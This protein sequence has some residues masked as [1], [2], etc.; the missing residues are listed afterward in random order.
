M[1]A[2]YR[3]VSGPGSILGG[4]LSLTGVGALVV[5][6]EQPGDANWLAA[7]PVTNRVT[8]GRGVQV[9]TF[10]PIGDQTLG[11]GPV[12]LVARASSGLPVTFSV[13]S[14][15]AAVDNDRLAFSAEGVVTVR[16]INPGSSLWLSASADQTIAVRKQTRLAVTVAGNLG[17]SVAVAPV[18]DQYLATDTVTLTATP[19]SGFAFSAWS[20]DLT[21][22]AN[23]ASLSM[24]ANRS[25]VA[26]FKDITPPSIIWEL[27]VAGTS[28]IELFRLLGK[29]NDNSTV[30]TVL[31][32]RDGGLGQPL[33]LGAD[34]SFKLENLV[35]ASGTNRFALVARDAAGNE[36]RLEREVVWMPQRI[37]R[38]AAADSSQEGQ[39]LVF[40]LELTSPGDVAGLTFELRYDP[41]F[42]AD[43]QIEWS[44]AVGQSVNN[45]NA[46]T[47]GKVAATFS[48]AGSALPG[49]IQR[50]A[51]VSFRGR[52]V[53]AAKTVDLE[54]RW[55]SASSSTGALLANGNA[56]VTGSGR[57]VPRRIQGD[58]N[59]N[60][61]I[62]IGDA[63]LISR[64]QVELEEVRPWDV[65]LNDL[66]GSGLIDN[67]DVV[68]ALR[69]VVGLDPQPT[70]GSEA[71]RLANALGLAKAQVNTNDAIILEA[72][73][74]PVATVGQPYRIAIRLNRVRG[75]LSGLRFTLNYPNGL[76]LTEKQVGALVPGDA[77]PFWNDGAG[78]VSLAAI[79]STPWPG[80]VGVAAVFTFVPDAA[81]GGQAEWPIRLDQAEI[82]GSGFD[83]RPLDPVTLTIRSQG[84]IDNRPSITLAPPKPDGTLGLEIIAPQGT[85][86]AVEATSDL[87]AWTETQRIT[88]Q[89]SGNPV[90]VTLQ[91]DPNVQA[92]F[93]RV[94]VR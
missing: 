59:A 88:G 33:T 71:K 34:G 45:V 89:G 87:S 2:G 79:R 28:G 49:G 18:K 5:V 94:R 22:S 76:S 46:T 27:P 17:G 4:Q 43:P 8:V 77:M 7:L 37:L 66:N 91:A 90:K 58:N 14:G 6:A 64:L 86:I 31:W 38:V 9:V 65:A 12:T 20:G 29:V 74:G 62:D 68:K 40:P 53:P 54:P 84:G 72:I 39:R 50:L 81:F 78:K 21:G 75:S 70:S 10:E 61:R 19:A 13:I 67:G 41:T 15:P 48:M 42:L 16:A 30:A 25:V 92:R 26:T 57:I 11:A 82:T 3:V 85:T 83:V 93:W 24:A 32:S 1:P 73:D 47:P 52:S 55:V 35:L 23:P 36:A 63:V 60:Q 69:A 56:V 44:A 51:T 80:S